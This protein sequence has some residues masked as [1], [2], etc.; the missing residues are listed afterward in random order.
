MLYKTSQNSFFKHR[1]SGFTLI[2]V[3]VAAVILFA[4]IA[5]VSMIYRGAFLSSEKANKHIV[6]S[7]VIPTALDEIR[8]NLRLKGSDPATEIEGSGEL[9]LVSYHWVANQVSFKAAPPALYWESND[10]ATEPLK[11]KLWKVQL[12]LFFNGTREYYE[13]NELSWN[14]K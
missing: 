7:G 5:V 14:E 3:M 10:D 11:Y 13:F 1:N 6:V 12:V 9:W 8:E 4:S 2:E